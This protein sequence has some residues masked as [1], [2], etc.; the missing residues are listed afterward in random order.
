MSSYLPGTRRIAV[1]AAACWTLLAI[2]TPAASAEP[3]TDALGFVNSTARCSTP[4][5][6]VAFGSTANSRVAICKSP[7]GA[8]GYHGVRISD[9]A[10]L[11]AAVTASSDGSFVAQKDGVTYT[12]TSNALTVS[13]ASGT[14]RS[15]P[16][17]S[18]HGPKTTKAPASAAQTPAAKPQAPAATLAPTT[19]P[20]STA[21]LPPPLPAEVGGTKH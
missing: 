11:I 17:V 3:S 12:V 16:M 15:E 19:A 20:S 5:T 10:T 6:A 4:N 7:A 18:Y 9:G 2:G 21:P 14:I 8:Y 1:A 13:D